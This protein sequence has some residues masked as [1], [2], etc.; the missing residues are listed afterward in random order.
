MAA[1]KAHDVYLVLDMH[2]APCSQMYAFVSDYVGPDYLWSSARCQDRM[3]AMWKAIAARYAKENI[4][5]GYDLLGET[6]ISDQE[7]L[8]LYKRATAAIREVDRN[9]TIIYEGN[10]MARTFDLFTAP[11]DGNQ[12]LSFHDY[13]WAF[14]GEDLSVRMAGYDAAARRLNTPQWAGEFGQSVYGDVEKYVDTFDA[15]PL[16]AG[17]A[18]WAWKQVPGFAPLQAI[19]H[20]AASKKLIE[21]MNDPARPRPTGAEAAQGMSDFARAVRFENTVHDAKLRRILACEGAC[22][23]PPAVAV[24]APGAGA[25]AAAPATADAP[26]GAP[27]APGT[28]APEAPA[29]LAATARRTTLGGALRHGVRVRVTLPGAGRLRVT[30]GHAGTRVARGARVRSGRVVARATTTA[31]GAGSRVVTL[32]F[33]RGAR[34]ALRRARRV[35]L[36]VD[37]SFTPARGAPLTRR[38]RVALAR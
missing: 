21:W 37:V 35:T 17:W 15:D 25:P 38:L 36:T 22:T 7:L 16:M 32:R 34:R 5:A 28:A 14:P 9:H 30:A 13:P 29:T 18:Q 11:L 27:G 26:V 1:A 23:V 10:Y 20:T 2:A 6:I 8:A 4:V 19:R 33:T 31:M 24:T 12:L 3:V